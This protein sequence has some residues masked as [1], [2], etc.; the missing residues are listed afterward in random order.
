M[1]D[2]FNKTIYKLWHQE[3]KEEIK[4]R[5]EL[6]KKKF[7]PMNEYKRKDKNPYKKYK[8]LEDFK[9]NNP[10][11]YTVSGVKS[12]TCQFSKNPDT[13]KDEKNRYFKHIN[14]E[15]QCKN[16]NGE[17]HENDINRFNKYDDGVCW[18]SYDHAICG[19][20]G[21]SDLLRPSYVKKHI[22]NGTINKQLQES[23]EECERDDRCKMSKMSKYSYDCIDKSL[24]EKD[25]GV[26]DVPDDFPTDITKMDKNAGKFLYDWYVEKK[27]PKPKTSELIGQ[28]NRCI[29][30]VKVGDEDKSS[31]FHNPKT[32]I[33]NHT[34]EE[35]KNLDPSKKENEIIVK[36][37]IENN[38]NL[39]TYRVSMLVDQIRRAFLTKEKGRIFDKLESSKIDNDNEIPINEDDGEFGVPTV[40]QSIV[41]SIMKGIAKNEK[42]SSRGILAWFSTG[43]GKTICAAGVMEAFWD[44]KRQIIFA[45]S[46]DALASNPPS[47]FYSAALNIFPRF[48]SDKY[49]GKTKEDTLKNIEKEFERRGVRFLSFAKLSNRVKKTEEYK[50]S[51]KTYVG[52]ASKKALENVNLKISDDDYVDLNNTILIIDEV[53]NLFRPEY[54]QAKQHEYLEDML[55][56][57]KKNTDKLKVTIL[58]ATPGD[59]IPDIVKLLNIVKKPEASPIK[60]PDTTSVES[61][62]AFK[63][64]IFGLISYFDMNGDVTKFPHVTDSKPILS[65]MSDLQFKR[66]S[67]AFSKDT[68]AEHKNFQKLAKDNKTS[69]YW[70]PARKYANMMF[71]YDKDMS[72]EEFGAKIP[73]ILS[74]FREYEKQ[75]HY[76]YSAFYERRGYGGHGV[77]AL[78][79]ELEKQ[80]YTKLTV[81]EAMEYNSKSTL[82]PP[83]KRYILAIA[84]EIEEGY[85][86]GTVGDNLK[87]LLNIYNHAEN[88][89]GELVHIML[90]SNKFNE[91]ID[92]KAVRHIHFFEPLVTMA[93]DMQTI[94]RAAR[95]CSHADLDIDNWTVKI[96]RYMTNMPSEDEFN[97]ISNKN[98]DA[99]IEA[100][101]KRIEK[102]D[103]T[104]KST[105]KKDKDLIV[106]IKSN[107]KKLKSEL[108]SLKKMNTDVKK[109]NNKNIENIEK[110]IFK[111]S[112]ERMKDIMVIYHAMREAA[113]DC[114]VMEEFHSTSTNP[115]KC[116]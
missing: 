14:N 40:P 104:L 31:D 59:N 48:Q 26:I 28:G 89:N 23:R 3:I 4:K 73:S 22:R 51:I 90:A 25:I 78:G 24:S 49:R 17:W 20:N 63:K 77:I 36:K 102:E 18:T 113:V 87:Q 83:G 107:I 50:K 46:L 88:A 5:D 94:G 75:K 9:S 44:T 2:K 100:I 110:K 12:S 64:E 38:Y 57:K 112:R 103:A 32:K 30:S 85:P 65:T 37:Y 29:K 67:E 10:F 76:V 61:I 114:K 53:H 115:V 101:E 27:Y 21:N 95:N 33:N 42:I 70:G 35:I 56:N 15:K 99:D 34:L 11:T 8:S 82:P 116:M 43:A 106:E 74:K 98:Y 81:K 93:S 47:S 62:E 1:T 109:I 105:D 6:C 72:L 68:T 91:G 60:E 39:D 96:H 7:G 80:G 58:T 41:N 55:L 45:S 71:N 84:K 97:T 79:K 13:E 92:L 16:V 52:G 54:N 108:T 19:R 69:K 86:K 111:E 66:Y